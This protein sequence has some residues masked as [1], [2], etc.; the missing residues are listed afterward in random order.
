MS[1]DSRT[2]F[3]ASIMSTISR[4]GV[5][6]ISTR[7]ASRTDGFSSSA[8]TSFGRRLATKYSRASHGVPGPEQRAREAFSSQPASVMR[9]CSPNMGWVERY[10]RISTISAEERASAPLAA[11]RITL[12]GTAD[13]LMS[14][15]IRAMVRLP[16][17]ALGREDDDAR[18]V[19][20]PELGQRLAV[21]RA[22]DAAGVAE[23]ELDALLGVD[24]LVVA[25]LHVELAH[26]LVVDLV[27]HPGVLL[28]ADLEQEP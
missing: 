28:G 3:D 15:I 9:A 26:R 27:A 22:L 23:H 21:V 14:S 2:R 13:C 7:R 12:A 19:L 1:R 11:E 10:T 20:G 24:L 8:G 6:A 5:C 17:H 25:R 16:L 4:S 18:L